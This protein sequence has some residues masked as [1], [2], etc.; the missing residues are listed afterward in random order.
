MIKKKEPKEHHETA[1]HDLGAN[2]F[3]MDALY[4]Y[5]VIMM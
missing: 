3:V 2:Y 1:C 5:L 4:Y